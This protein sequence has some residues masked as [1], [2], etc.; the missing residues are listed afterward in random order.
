MQVFNKYQEILKDCLLNDVNEKV[1]IDV[2]LLQSAKLAAIGEIVAGVAHELNN[3]LTVIIGN[4]Q[5]MLREKEED[6]DKSELLKDIVNSGR[7]CKRII[8]DLLNF[9]RQDHYKSELID[10]NEEVNQVLRIIKYQINQDKI[11]IFKNLAPNLPKIN[12]HG[13]QLQQVLINFLL[14]ARD[15]LEGIKHEKKI[16]I[17]TLLRVVEN[18]E[19]KIAVTVRDNGVGIAPEE[20][21]H[22]FDPFYTSKKEKKGTGLGLWISQKIAKSHG[23]KIEVVSLQ[24]EG[25]AFSLIMPVEA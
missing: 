2:Q 22:I 13:H 5:L 11:K 12:A 23:G 16:E 14:N 25:S 9:S 18:K 4:A 3:P 17:S 15:A 21:P 1:G 19:R 20:M 8:S 7:R 6:S 10:I 24:G